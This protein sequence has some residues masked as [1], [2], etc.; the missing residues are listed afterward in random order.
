MF[1]ARKIDSKG[2]VMLGSEYA[3]AI[4]LLEQAENGDII[5]HPAAVVP[6]SEAWLHNNPKAAASVARGLKQAS[7]DQFAGDPIDIDGEDW[8]KDE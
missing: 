1:E 6:L 8:L 2:R 3:G 5:I 7:E 4:V